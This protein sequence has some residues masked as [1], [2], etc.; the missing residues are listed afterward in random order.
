MGLA[1]IHQYPPSKYALQTCD[2]C[3][4]VGGRLGNQMNFGNPPLFPDSCT[5]VCVNGSHEE[6][7]NN[8]AADHVL[9]SDPGAF[10]EQLQSLNPFDVE[11]LEDNRTKRGEWVERSLSDLKAE[12]A[13]PDWGVIRS[14]RWN[15]HLM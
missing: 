11:W 3:I 13:S 15:W 14:I 1:D 9:L 5:L 12:T 2:V 7:D 10:F 4:M 6:L 8:R